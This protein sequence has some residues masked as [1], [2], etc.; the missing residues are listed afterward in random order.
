MRF[1][2]LLCWQEHVAPRR[3]IGAWILLFSFF[4]KLSRITRTWDPHSLSC[5]PPAS[6]WSAIYILVLLIVTGSWGVV[7]GHVFCSVVQWT[8]PPVGGVLCVF[9]RAFVCFRNLTKIYS[10][11]RTTVFILASVCTWMDCHVHFIAFL[12][13]SGTRGY[14]PGAVIYRVRPGTYRHVGGVPL[15][16]IVSLCFKYSARF[17]RTCVLLHSP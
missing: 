17:T 12:F 4:Q 3:R 14:L 9:N 6:W 7:V 1:F 10:E 16:F 2:I 8:Y 5:L 13:V 11:L 15:L